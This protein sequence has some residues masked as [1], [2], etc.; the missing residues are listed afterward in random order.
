MRWWSGGDDDDD[1]DDV[2]VVVAEL[3]SY[4]VYCLK[5][6]IANTK[7]FMFMH[8]TKRVITVP[9]ELL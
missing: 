5:Y 2:T 6:L 7:V 3:P 9:V 1:D 4:S 8:Y